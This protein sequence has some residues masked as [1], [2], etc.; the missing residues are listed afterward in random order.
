MHRTPGFSV[1]GFRSSGCDTVAEYIEILQ[2]AKALQ[3]FRLQ[4]N[5][6]RTRGIEWRLSLRE[7]WEI[8][9][10][11]GHW[12]NRGRLSLQYVMCRHG[13]CGPYAVGNVYIATVMQNLQDAWKNGRTTGRPR[14][15][16]EATI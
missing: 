10:A 14:R 7:W 6:A 9:Q 11:S 1:N 13:D 15:I 2:T 5:N 16:A 4:K 12:N 3:A 8:W